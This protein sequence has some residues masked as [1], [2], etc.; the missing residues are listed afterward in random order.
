MAFIT[1]ADLIKMII[2]GN[3][4]MTPAQIVGEEIGEFKASPEYQLMLVSEQY[5]RNRSA[6]QGKTVKIDTRSNTKIEHPILRKLVNQKTS[7][8][9]SSPFSV[10]SENKAY[11]AA[12]G[13][14]FDD[15]FRGKIKGMATDA[16]KY[17]IG[18]LQPYFDQGSLYWARLPSTEVIPLWEDAEHERLYGFIRFYQQTVY[19]GTSKREITRAELWTTA[20]VQYFVNNDGVFREDDEQP[21]QSHF[22]LGN[23]AYN[24]EQVPLVWLRYNDDEL[25]LLYFI[26]ELIDDVNWQKSV[27]ADALRDVV[28]FIYILKNY[29]GQSLAEFIQGL[30]DHLAIQVDADGGV[31][32]LNAEINIDAVMK[33]LDAQRRDLYDYGSGVD[34]KDPDLGNASGT[35]IN[36][37]YMDLDADCRALGAEL[38]VSLQRAKLFIDF[39]LQAIGK[40]GFTDQSF[41][42]TFATEMPV[43]EKEVIENAKNSVGI[44]SN[45]TII[46][47]HPWVENPEEEVKQLDK[48]R[49]EVVEQTR[50]EYPGDVNLDDQGGEDE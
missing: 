8:L 7:Y 19:E 24:W 3:A 40:G 5:W 18:Y 12:L 39:Y 36:F 42:V 11:T 28:N 46:K 14:V 9:L 34:V 25:P 31:D 4:P 6:V 43:N 35:A 33:F 38:K 30:K 47:N 23:T 48:E 13:E 44:I 27:T 17:G 50:I 32:K 22:T 2:E 41:D 45:A 29:G 49:Q 21:A 20:G 37:R 26:R 1:Q 15:A 10:A 16:I